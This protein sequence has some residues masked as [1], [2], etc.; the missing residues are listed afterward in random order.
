M[1]EPPAEGMAEPL[2]PAVHEAKGQALQ[3]R[4][5]RGQAW[6]TLAANDRNPSPAGVFCRK[7]KSLAYITKRS[8]GLLASDTPGSKHLT[9]VRIQKA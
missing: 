3:Q 8:M 6:C 2:Q 4:K 5:D 1:K 7:G 9:V